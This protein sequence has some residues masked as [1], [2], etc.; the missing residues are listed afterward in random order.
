MPGVFSQLHHVCLVV[1][2]LEATMAAYER[3]G[4]TGWYDYP[5][6]GPYVE[7]EVPDPVGSANL[8]YKCCDLGNVQLQLCQ[9]GSEGTPQRRFLDEYGEGVYH[10]GF[11]VED[12]PAS[13]AAGRALGLDVIARGLRGDGS[14]FAY[15]DTQHLTKVILEVRRTPAKEG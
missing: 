12:L 13:L 8:R 15:F 10:L 3:L 14:G 6:H 4:V 5:S 11:E 2:D 1:A 7:L 9:P